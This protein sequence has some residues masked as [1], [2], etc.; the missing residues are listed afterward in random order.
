MQPCSGWLRWCGTS[1]CTAN[2][3]FAAVKLGSRMPGLGREFQFATFGCGRSVAILSELSVDTR[4]C[5]LSPDSDLLDE[6]GERPFPKW[7]GRSPRKPPRSAF[8]S[9]R[10]SASQSRTAADSLRRS[11]AA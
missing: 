11:F 8:G 6:V 2:D 10:H 3:C 7:T 5:P 9:R 1:D 4:E